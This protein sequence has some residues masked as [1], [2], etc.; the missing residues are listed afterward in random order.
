MADEE[1]LV[2]DLEGLTTRDENTYL[3]LVGKFLSEQ[4]INLNI[5]KGC[6]AGI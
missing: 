2:I 6:L 3:C 4:T 5:S 1:E